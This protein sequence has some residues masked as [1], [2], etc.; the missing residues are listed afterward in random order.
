[1]RMPRD[2][3]RSRNAFQ[4]SGSSATLV[5][6]P[7]SEKLRLIRPLSV[8]SR[9]VRAHDTVSATLGARGGL[10]IRAGV[11]LVLAILY[12]SFVRAAV[13]EAG[14]GKQFEKPS[15]AIAVAKDGDTVRVAA[16]EYEDCATIRQNRFTLEG[17]G[18]DVVLKNKTCAGKAILVI[19]GTKVTIRGLTL[20]NAKVPDRN[21]A[22]IRAEGGELL[23]ENTR[24]LANENGLMSANELNISI[25]VVDSTFIGNGQCRPTCTHGIYAGHIRF[26]RVEHSKFLEQHEGHHIKSRA[27]RTEVVG[28]DIQD[29]PAGNSSYLIEI[30][31]GGA[32]LIEKN[33]MSKGRMTSNGGAAISIGAEGDTNP[34]GPII[35]RDNVFVNEQDRPT[36][37]VRDFAATPAEL[38]GNL[39]TG[40]V[41]PLAGAGTVR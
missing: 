9:P 3:A 36:V 10:M 8:R 4:N 17:V 23:V 22:G 6:C 31:N 11:W 39:L 20:A 13:L 30:P 25:R 35:V 2:R 29:G 27:A 19:D 7:A 18:G 16:G 33:Q 12:P 40:V 5:R 21:G 32:A 15:T 38:S 37:F 14:A 41:T 26:L 24:F 1:M 28:C 34:P